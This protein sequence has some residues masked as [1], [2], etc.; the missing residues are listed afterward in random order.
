MTEPEHID[1][2]AFGDH[3]TALQWGSYEAVIRHLMQIN[4]IT[5]DGLHLIRREL[6]GGTWFH[7]PAHLEGMRLLL[8]ADVCTAISAVTS[9]PLDYFRGQGDMPEVVPDDVSGIE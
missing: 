6:K 7:M 4:G 8:L 1:Y 3:T 5:A 9:M 2:P